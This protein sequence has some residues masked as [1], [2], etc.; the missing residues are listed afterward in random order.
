MLARAGGASGP[1]AVAST[2]EQHFSDAVRAGTWDAAAAAIVKVAAPAPELAPLPVDKLRLLQDALARG[3][4]K[5]GPAAGV[6]LG[7]I[8]TELQ[9]KG[10]AAAKVAPGAAYGN[11]VV[12][13]SPPIDGDPAT[14]RPYERGMAFEFWPDLA[15]IDADQIAFIQT[16]RVV[17]T[18]TSNNLDPDRDNQGRQTP[19][20]TS[21]D[22]TKGE[23]GWY[24]MDDDQTGSGSL[25]IW[26]RANPATPAW[27]LDRPSG[28]VTNSTWQFETAVVCCAGA[29]LGKVYATVTWGFTVDA[30]QK[31]KPIDPVVTNKP[32]REFSF[33]VTL[34]NMQAAGPVADRQS[35]NQQPLPALN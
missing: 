6:V 8:D 29:D 33:A 2:P 5:L 15:V 1:V 23:Q 19:A 16:V 14:G 13:P 27:M 25:T 20:H 11:V 31:V 22:K 34:W 28:T 12:K 21:V 10:V 26:D 18:A 7:H 35:P 4:A 24:M 9:A 3:G 17:A 30:R 32:T